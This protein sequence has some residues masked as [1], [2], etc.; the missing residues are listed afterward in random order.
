MQ[1]A[2]Q[3]SLGLAHYAKVLVR[4]WRVVVILTL[5]GVVASVACAYLLPRVYTAK[6]TVNLNIIT[7]E[8]FTPQ[9][10]ASGLLDGNTEAAIARS[11][12]VAARAAATL[13]H[14]TTAREVRAA[15]Q[16]LTSSD[17]TV[18][19]VTYIAHSEHRATA[20]ADA[21]AKAYLGYRNEQAAERVQT[22]ITG[23]NR[24]IEGLQK[25]LKKANQTLAA[26]KTGSIAEIDAKAQ[27]QQ[28]L[29]EMNDLLSARNELSGVDTTGGTVLTAAA[30]NPTY[31]Q[32]ARTKL[33]LTGAAAGLVLGILLAYLGNPFDRRV[34]SAKEASSAVGAPVLAGGRPP[35]GAPAVDQDQT[36]QLA[37][38][39]ILARVTDGAQV[40]L[41]DCTQDAAG[42]TALLAEHLGRAERAVQCIVASAAEATEVVA[43]MAAADAAVL[44]FDRD[45]GDLSRMRWVAFEA[46]ANATEIL[47]V[48]DT[49]GAGAGHRA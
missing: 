42:Y 47:G 2:D 23:Y 29:T 9:R 43:G 28:V 10:A 24:Q 48:V 35:R 49:T 33:V 30:D 18:V 45:A 7:S 25:Q 44:V 20:G 36:L 21:V 14:G 27:Q 12:L 4:Q 38:E 13:G 41:V 19:N 5:V 39:R 32:P 6:T 8:P 26:S 15:S 3:T 11:Q 16:V 22:M 40:M 34:R 17:A 1:Q 46:R 37:C 31:A